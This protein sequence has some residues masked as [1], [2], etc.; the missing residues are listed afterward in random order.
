MGWPEAQG[1][2]T[3]SPEQGPQAVGKT[4]V[5]QLGER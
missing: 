5:G 2:C 3:I 4:P 1:F